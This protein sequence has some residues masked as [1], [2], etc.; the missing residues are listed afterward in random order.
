VARQTE[1]TTSL[2]PDSGRCLHYYFY[3]IDEEFGLCYLRV[4]TWAPYRLQF[5]FNM[6]NWLARRL[7]AEGIGYRLVDNDFVEI[8]DFDAA[9][10]IVDGFDP[11]RLHRKLE[12][13]TRLYCPAAQAFPAGY[14]WSLMQAEFATDIVFRRRADL[15]PLYQHLVRTA[16]HTVRA[17]NVAIFLGRRLDPRYEGELGTDFHTRIEGTRIKL[18]AVRSR[19][20]RACPDAPTHA[21]SSGCS[22]APRPRHVCEDAVVAVAVDARRRDEASERG[23]EVER[24]EYEQ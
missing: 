1:G 3:F 11:A 2:R 6:H 14:H 20:R 21:H 13:W 23:E 5:Y 12:A 17:E 10:Q 8:K 7:D 18:R 4:P 9:Q 19:L 15:D 24:R 22:K 16:I